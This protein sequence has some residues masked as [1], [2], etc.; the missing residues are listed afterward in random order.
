MLI[1]VAC[2]EEFRAIVLIL[3]S[4]DDALDHLDAL[5][6]LVERRHEKFVAL[7]LKCVTPKLHSLQ[8]A[9]DCMRLHHANMSCF[10]GERQQAI[11]RQVGAVAFKQCQDTVLRSALR[12][13]MDCYAVEGTFEEMALG[14]NCV[15]LIGAASVF[16]PSLQT[17]RAWTCNNASNKSGG[18]RKD[19]LLSWWDGD[20]MRAGFANLF[21]K[22]E[23]NLHALSYQAS[24]REVLNMGFGVNIWSRRVADSSTLISMDQVR[25]ITYARL[26]EDRLFLLF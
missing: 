18:M 17:I 10:P 13:I 15:E 3:R 8:H 12:K 25:A 9:A 16:D 4:G 23:D 20:V 19:D 14:E 26:D 11:P 24:V 6:D 5:D 21:I 22:M 7:Y 2:L 1:H